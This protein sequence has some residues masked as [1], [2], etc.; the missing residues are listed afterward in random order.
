MPLS[1][2]A[3]AF[4]SSPEATEIRNELTRMMEDDGYNTQPK[5]SALAKGDVLFV[6]KHITYLSLHLEIDPA[7]YMSNL[8]L[9]TKYN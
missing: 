4:L 7:Q 3:Q 8:R 9:I 1:F 5:Y 6:D 2:K